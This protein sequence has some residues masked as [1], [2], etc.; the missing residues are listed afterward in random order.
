MPPR[1]KISM[2]DDLIKEMSDPMLEFQGFL[3]KGDL[4]N[5]VV[6]NQM[7]KYVELLDLVKD[8]LK[9]RTNHQS[10][11]F[12]EVTLIPHVAVEW[13]GLCGQR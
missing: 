4:L 6:S 13:I 2:D 8:Y 12:T 10:T 3:K 1:K 5:V 11:P 9:I 7:F